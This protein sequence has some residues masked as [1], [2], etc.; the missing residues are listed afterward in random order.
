MFGFRT[1]FQNFAPYQSGKSLFSGN[2]EVFL[3]TNENPF[4]N[5][6][7][8][9]PSPMHTALR[10]KIAEVKNQQFSS[11]ISF[12]NIL[13]GNGSD[14]LIDLLVRLFCEPNQESILIT[15]PTFGMYTVAAKLNNVETLEVWLDEDFEL[16]LENL[17]AKIEEK[18]PKITFL[19]H[20]NNP[21]G[22]ALHIDDIEKI[23]KTTKNIVVVDEAYIDFCP[24]KSVLAWLSDFPNLVVLHTFSKMWGLA[25]LR[26]G[27]VMAHSE[28]I[29][30]LSALKMP[31]NVN[32]FTANAVIEALNEKEKIFLQRDV[33]LAEKKKLQKAYSSLLCI[34]TVFSS[35]SN[36]FLL[37]FFDAQKAYE[38]LKNAGIIVRNFSSKKGLENC[39]RI[40]V[41][42]P[43]ENVR[44]IEVLKS[45]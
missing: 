41:G 1:C 34:Q 31:Y 33:I 30:K 16:N 18:N 45:I 35:D 5:G 24:E 29:S 44:V 37:K 14:E 19:C 21:T 3:D 13:L 32:V 6:K 12:D 39:L 11:T 23:L 42:T 2:A 22:N 15:P 9:Y 4:D 36:F 25:G 10:E 20:P 40:T 43:A 27:C 17:L 38:T 8:R 26:C 28:I 7:N